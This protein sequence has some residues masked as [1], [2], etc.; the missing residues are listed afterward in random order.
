MGRK[1][2]QRAERTVMAD[3]RSLEMPKKVCSRALSKMLMDSD[4]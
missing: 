2:L 1:T 4:F 3:P